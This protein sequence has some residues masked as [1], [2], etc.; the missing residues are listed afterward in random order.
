VLLLTAIFAT[1]HTV[2]W[3]THWIELI[4]DPEQKTIGRPRHGVGSP[5]KKASF[6]TFF[7]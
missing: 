5:I 7:L 4:A 3:I 2:G 1:T 6:G